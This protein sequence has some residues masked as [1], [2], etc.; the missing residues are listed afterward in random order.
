VAPIPLLVTGASGLRIAGLLLLLLGLV[1]CLVVGRRMPARGAARMPFWG[2]VE[3]LRR[4]LVLSVAAWLGAATLCFTFGASE[5]KG[6][7][8]PRASLH[9]SLAAQAFRALAGHLV[10]EGVELVVTR[11]MDAFMA[12]FGVA[13]GL[14]AVLAMPFMVQQL[15]GFLSPALRP[16][17]RR[18]L[19]RLL[20]PLVLL[21]VAGIAFSLLVVLPFTLEALYAFA[22]PIGARP[23]LGVSTLAGFALGFC[24]AFGIAFQTPVAMV[25]LARAGVVEP[26]TFIRYWRHAVVAIVVLSAFLTPDPTLLSQVMMAGPL[27]LL[28]A[29]GAGWSVVSVRRAEQRESAAAHRVA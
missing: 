24:L 22:G 2:H 3:E 23:L 12:E 21:F 13:L 4:R 9:E 25:G 6:W 17:E 27:V 8:V 18:F 5:W 15:G 1:A 7:A 19:G 10:P 29:V 16:R 14:G 20:L 28:Y 26:A 11:P